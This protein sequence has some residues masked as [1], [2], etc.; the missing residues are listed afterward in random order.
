MI[1]WRLNA[2]NF[3]TTLLLEEIIIKDL[4]RKLRDLKVNYIMQRL[5]VADLD[6]QENFTT[7]ISKAYKSLIEVFSETQIKILPSY[8]KEDYAAP[9]VGFFLGWVKMGWVWVGFGLG[10]T[11]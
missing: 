11:Q 1:Q 4:M 7:L 8:H 6:E 10:L 2:E 9:W 5:Q 3:L